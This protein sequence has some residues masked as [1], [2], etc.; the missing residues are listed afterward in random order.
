MNIIITIYLYFG[1]ILFFTI[2]CDMII[3]GDLF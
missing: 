3:E 2:F 1:T